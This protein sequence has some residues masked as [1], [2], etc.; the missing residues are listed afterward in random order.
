MNTP[1]LKAEKGG[2]CKEFYND[3]EFELWK[4]DND[5]KGWRIKYYK[6]LG[7]STSKEFK[8]YFAK[9]K[10]VAFESTDKSKQ[11]IDMVFNKKRSD[12]RKD[13]LASYNRE[14]YLDTNKSTV[15]Y[16]EFINNEA[17]TDRHTDKINIEPVLIGFRNAHQK[18]ETFIINRS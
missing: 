8:E 9:K 4:K 13:W 14:L 1:I 16:E 3:G 10:I 6:G 15:T 17:I 2:I 7:T 12:D 5:I 18:I 11:M